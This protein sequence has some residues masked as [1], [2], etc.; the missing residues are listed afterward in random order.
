VHGIEERNDIMSPI[1]GSRL[2]RPHGGRLVDRVLKNRP[3]EDLLKCLPVLVVSKETAMDAEQIAIGTFSPLQGF[4]C[5]DDFHGVLDEMRLKNGSIWTL[6]IVLQV[7][8]QE[9]RRLRVGSDVLLV[10]RESHRKVAVLHLESIYRIDPVDVAKR[11]FGTAN[12]DHPGAKEMLRSGDFLLGGRVDLIERTPRHYKEY[13]STPA[14]TRRVFE[15]MGWTKII[16]FHT[17]NVIHRSHEFIQNEGLQRSGCDGLFVHP[18]IGKKKKGDFETAAIIQTYEL[19]IKAFY[20]AGRVVFGTFATFSRY[21]GPREAVFTALCRQNFG[22]SHFIVGRDHTGVGSFY[23][24]REA[25]EIFSKFPELDIKPVFFD[26][27]AYCE[28]CGRHVQAKDC[29]HE[30]GSRKSIS[31]TKLREMIEG[32]ET[33]PEWFMRPEIART[34]FDMK[35]KGMKLFVE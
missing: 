16:A 9:A 6:P 4:L 3:T 14:Q 18:V 11:W 25:H 33:P 29:P 17:R 24:T 2:I 23:D 7:E 5:E 12:A 13:E 21:A 1:A 31:G 26:E 10:E 28:R 27:V 34:L 30:R 19:M 20:P 8:R 15:S 35:L 32:G 22:C